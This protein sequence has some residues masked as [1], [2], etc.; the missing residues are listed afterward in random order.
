MYHGS[1]LS[2]EW[3]FTL[4]ENVV[5]VGRTE[6]DLLI[7]KLSLCIIVP[8]LIIVEKN[9]SMSKPGTQV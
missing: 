4:N 1:C 6:F 9:E 3:V 7:S 2:T 5:S 8:Y